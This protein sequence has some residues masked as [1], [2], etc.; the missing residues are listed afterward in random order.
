[1]LRYGAWACAAL[2]AATITAGLVGADDKSGFKSG[3]QVGDPATPFQVRNITGQKS[4]C[5]YAQD[6]RGSLCYR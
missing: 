6:D 3:L 5:S 1:M 4:A 2:L